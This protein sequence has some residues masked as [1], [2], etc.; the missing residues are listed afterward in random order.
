MKF[1]SHITIFLILALG[2]F[3]ADSTFA[4][5]SKKVVA[6]S[7]SSKGTPLSVGAVSFLLPD[8]LT[9][10]DDGKADNIL[11]AFDAKEK[12]GLFLGVPGKNADQVVTM[13][14]TYEKGLRILFAQENAFTWKESSMYYN[15]QFSNYETEQFAISGVGVTRRSAINGRTIKLKGKEFF[16]GYLLLDDITKVGPDDIQE[17]RNACQSILKVIRSITNEK[18]GKGEDLCVASLMETSQL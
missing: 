15:S 17:S 10:K 14:D 1:I 7:A 8:N 5:Q 16:V 2:H 11:L 13:A 6:Q 4:Q 12:Y 3:V 18:P 9:L